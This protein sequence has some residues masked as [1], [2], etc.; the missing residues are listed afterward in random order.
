MKSPQEVKQDIPFLRN[1]SYWESTAVGPTLKP[2]IDAM[3]DYYENRPFNFE[4]GACKPALETIASV[5]KAIESVAKFINASPEEVSL[6]P[7]NTTEAINM[8]IQ[9]LPLKEGDEII[10]SNIDHMAAYMPVLRLMKE[11]G[12]KFELIKADEQGGVDLPEYK[13]RLTKKTKLIIL[14][15]SGNIYGNILDAKAICTLARENG[16]YSMLDAAQTIARMPIDVK[17]IGCDFLNTCAR[18]HLCGPQGTAILYVRKGLSEQLEPII[19][20]GQHHADIVGDYEYKLFPGIKRF[21]AG[22]LNTSGVIGL[23]AAVDYWQEIGMD[24]V[25]RHCVEMQERLFKG[26]EEIGSVVYSPR[27][28]EIQVGIISFRINGLHPD[29][30]IKPLEEKYRI[31]IRSGAPGSPVFKE[32]GVDKINRMAAHYYTTKDD[33]EQLLKAMKE[34]RDQ[35]GRK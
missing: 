29:A 18:K 35:Y 25:R 22:I 19:I 27:K 9:G 14:C 26:L 24:A 2:V 20:G 11:R 4:G 30:L 6:F 12:I 32:L 5:Q 1:Y 15:H 21:N 7:K 23:G 8:V 16:A 31:V 33:V 3:T 34:I 17:D 13:K 10:G 28:S